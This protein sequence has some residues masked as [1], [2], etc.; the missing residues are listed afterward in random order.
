MYNSGLTGG[1]VVSIGIGAFV[2]GMIVQLLK[3]E[4]VGSLRL[5]AF[6]V[7]IAVM[8]AVASLLGCPEE[9]LVGLDTQYLNETFV[10]IFFTKINGFNTETHTHAR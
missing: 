4:I 10:L 9:I 1:V 8:I 7:A 6:S 5:C 3:L 2:G